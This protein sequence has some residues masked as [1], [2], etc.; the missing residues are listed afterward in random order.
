MAI[1]FEESFV[2][3]QAPNANAIKNG[4]GLV[5]KGKF[6]VL[7]RD[8]AD[9]ILFGECAGSGK[10]N[11][12]CS[13]DF[14]KA[15]SPTFRCSCPSRQ[16]PC[17]H[18]I[19]LMYAF[20]DGQTFSVA[21][22]PEDVAAK[23][24]K[25][26]VRAEK[27]ATAATQPAKPRKVNKAALKKKITAQLEGLDLLETLVSDLIRGGLGSLNAKTASQIEEQ[28]KQL[29]NAFLPGAQSALY[30]F[31]GLFTRNLSWWEL[32]Y[33]DDKESTVDRDSIYSEALDRLNRVHALVKHGRAYLTSRLED[34][35]L[36]P[37]T[38]SDIAAWLGHAWQ[39]RELGDAGLVEE[40]AELMQLAFHCTDSSARREWIDVGIWLNLG[41]GAVQLTKNFRPYRAAQHIKE[42][43]SFFQAVTATHLYLYPGDMNPRV[44]WEEMVARDLTSKDISNIRKHADSDL[45]AVIKS[46]KGQLKS[47]LSSKR[48]LMLVKFS[49]IGK[50]GDEVVLEDKNGNRIVLHESPQRDVPGM[51]HL[52]P[53][54]P[55][56]ALKNQVALLQFHHQ[57]DEKTLS[58]EPL[59]LVTESEIL[60][61][62]Y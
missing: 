36:K 52:L 60:R 40:N 1:S 61:L 14:I 12:H 54:L 8:K 44:R 15:D 57:L 48:P 58:A 30:E 22:V 16:F 21:E 7:H 62:T 19:G 34:P 50:I 51:L 10:S 37:E 17:K 11:Y 24:E 31:T 2:D 33:A 32:Q 41:S 43:D 35:E 45:A 55:P 46:V 39:L 42:E 59:S 5:L 13:A 47:P 49:R 23:R 28:A 18:T 4:R 53:M 3:S 29:G 20:T 38:K 6:V 25:A 27:K 26:E 9:T 56:G